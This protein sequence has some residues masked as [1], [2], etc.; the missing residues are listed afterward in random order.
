VVRNWVFSEGL[1]VPKVV[2]KSHS[3]GVKSK[4]FTMKSQGRIHIS[5]L[6]LQGEKLENWSKTGFSVISRKHPKWSRQ[7]L[8][9]AVIDNLDSDPESGARHQLVAAGGR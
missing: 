4:I 3:F 6:E 1:E 2:W 8:Y 9:F 5:S 7:V